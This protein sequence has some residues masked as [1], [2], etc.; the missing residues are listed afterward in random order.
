MLIVDDN[1]VNRRILSEQVARWGM[2]PTLVDGG[3]AALD[4][5]TAA[6]RD[7]RPF[8]LVLLDANMPDMDGFAVAAGDRRRPRARR[9][10]DHDADL[11]RASSA[12]SRAAP[13]SAS[14][15]I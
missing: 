11:V 3:R 13:S 15:R 4:A 5:L 6:A 8:E 2:T 14:P 1:D 9:R 10:D 7:G 12:I